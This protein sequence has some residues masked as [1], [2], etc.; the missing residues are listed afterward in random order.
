MSCD[1]RDESLC[2]PEE[3]PKSLQS[4]SSFM[5]P[6]WKTGDWSNCSVTCG[7]GVQSRIVTCEVSHENFTCDETQKPA[8]EKICFEK[9]R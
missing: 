1:D 2:L 5:C 9:V 7:K 8:V 3:K 6:V 4:C